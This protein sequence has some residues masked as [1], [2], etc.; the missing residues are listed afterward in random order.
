MIRALSILVCFAIACGPSRREVALAK[1]A[2]YNADKAVLFEL[3]RDAVAR[4]HKISHS[5]ETVLTIITRGRWY[6]PE[7]LASQFDIPGDVIDSVDAQRGT[8]GDPFQ[9]TAKS[10]LPD[11]SL[12]IQMTIRLLPEEK[13][14]IVYVSTKVA[15]YNAGMPVLE[16]VNTTRIDTPPWVLGKVDQ[17]SYEIHKSLREYQVRGLTGSTPEIP[18]DPTP[19]VDDNPAEPHPIDLP[20]SDTPDDSGEPAPQ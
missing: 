14:W 9:T 16:P 17:L 12:F 15:R 8:R 10:A 6:T 19:I 18:Y 3:T 13:N 20:K 7:G 11:K 2:R 1:M 5:D 4:K